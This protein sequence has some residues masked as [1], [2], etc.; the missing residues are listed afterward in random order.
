MAVAVEVAHQ[1]NGIGGELLG[2]G[3]HKCRVGPLCRLVDR[4]TFF[5]IQHNRFLA[6]AANQIDNRFTVPAIPGCRHS[7]TDDITAARREGVGGVFLRRSSAIA[8][9]PQIGSYRHIR[10]HCAIGIMGNGA[11]IGKLH[12]G[13]RH[14]RNIEVSPQVVRRFG[15]LFRRHRLGERALVAG[16]TCERHRALIRLGA[17]QRNSA[18]LSMG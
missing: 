16:S 14:R 7:E 13:T 4:Q 9:I 1:R 10:R 2:T 5:H 11:V 17:A 8:E 18:G 15:Y 3:P 12:R 6:G